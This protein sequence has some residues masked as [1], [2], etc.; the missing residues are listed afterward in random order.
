MRTF[1]LGKYHRY[2]DE[3]TNMMLQQNPHWNPE[4]DNGKGD[5]LWRTALAYITWQEP[6]MKQGILDCFRKFTMINKDGKY[7]YQAMRHTGRHREDD[8]SRDQTILAFASLKVN[9]DQ[10]ELNELLDHFPYKISRRF[11][12]TPT[13]WFWL[14]D[15]RGSR[16]AGYISL[17]LAL[18]ETT[19][20][21]TL[22]KL[23]ESILGL[24]EIHQDDYDHRLYYKKKENW[25]R[26]QLFVDK[27]MWPGYA[28]HLMHWHVYTS[29][30]NF[31]KRIL[32]KLLLSYTEKGNLLFRLLC[33]DKTVTLED[34]NNYK[35][36]N[37]WRWSIR[38]DGSSSSECSF[39][40]DLSANQMDKDIL[41]KIYALNNKTN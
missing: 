32:E 41:Y 34:I 15:L 2:F 9:G 26:F 16:W 11:T 21:V 22:N 5:A 17:F 40:Y 4:G 38:M 12:Q 39:N 13:M 33:R 30:D 14:K 28:Q 19:V 24:K 29:S 8:V 3:D 25:N 35:P 36:M 37:N 10:D 7:W 18:I 23:Y 6:S 20:S 31:I 1:K 27:I